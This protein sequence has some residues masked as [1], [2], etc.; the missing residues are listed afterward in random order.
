MIQQPSTSA[1]DKG[2]ETQAEIPTQIGGR[3]FMSLR[4]NVISKRR[5][6]R[7]DLTP[8]Q[9]YL[10]DDITLGTVYN[11]KSQNEF[12][13]KELARG[14]KVPPN[15]IYELLKDLEERKLIVRKPTQYR[16][17]ETL[18][19]SAEIFGQILSNHQN[20][21]EK[22][23]HLRLVKT[24][25][26]SGDVG[27]ENDS[28]GRKN[29]TASRE[30]DSSSRESDKTST[31]DPDIPKEKPPLDSLDP[32]DSLRRNP[33]E[34]SS[35]SGEERDRGID[36]TTGLRYEPKT[37]PPLELKLQFRHLFKSMQR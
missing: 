14:L 36:P 9:N 13:L 6:I 4:H 16:G 33:G 30:S 23:K 3:E 26:P 18:G 25:K 34:A 15:R 21:I 31:Q 27:R 20:D 28:G 32:L 5:E 11:W 7:R 35:D 37:Q 10:L 2:E 24:D 12:D 8:L 19:L 1:A 29:D 17:R 22:V